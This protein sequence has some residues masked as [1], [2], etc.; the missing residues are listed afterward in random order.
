[1]KLSTAIRRFDAQLRADGKSPHTRAVYLRDLESFAA[2]VGKTTDTG[3]I[4]PTH[5]ARYL[6]SASFTHMPCGEPRAV[7]SLNRSKSAIRSFFRFLTE[8]GHLKQTPARLVR[9]AP[10]HQKPPACLTEKEAYKL[11]ATIKRE[12]TLIAQRDHLIFAL[13]LGTGIRL[14][15]LVALNAGNVDLA[16]G[17]IRVNGKGN[18][19]QLVFVNGRLKRLLKKHIGKRDAVHP[20]F[21]S[22][23]GRRIGSRQVQLRLGHW[24]RRAGIT[25]PCTVHTLRHSFATR[26]YEKTGDLRLVRRAL[27]HRQ[28]TTTEIYSPVADG[29]LIRALRSLRLL[30]QPN[31]RN[32]KEWRPSMPRE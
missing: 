27:G 20:V 12:K 13:M 21:L 1:M 6:G 19:E 8:A 2:W 18:V 28:I 11:L 3:R 32:T 15:S 5:L 9:S 31:R 22:V 24:L 25:R 17:T 7:V 10:C 14:G 26:L 30:P 16:S 23:R 4:R 29:R